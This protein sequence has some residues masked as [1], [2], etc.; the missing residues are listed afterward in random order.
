MKSEI[1]CNRLLYYYCPICNCTDE[2]VYQG[3]DVGIL[4]AGIEP[5]ILSRCPLLLASLDSIRKT[6][7]N[8]TIISLTYCSYGGFKLSGSSYPK[9][10]SARGETMHQTPNV[11]EVQERARS[12]LSPCQVCW[13]RISPAAGAA[14]NVEFLPAALRIAQ[15]CR[16]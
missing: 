12:S 13:S 8:L 16:Y 2:T 9:L 1:K 11:L 5:A 6:V 15:N 4:H 3:S 10:F 7:K 14:K